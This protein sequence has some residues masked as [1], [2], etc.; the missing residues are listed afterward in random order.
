MDVSMPSDIALKHLYSVQ[1]V[2]PLITPHRLLFQAPECHGQVAVCAGLP[3]RRH[4]H[5][6]GAITGTL[7]QE[8]W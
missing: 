6:S 2:E 5:P 8:P 7:G 3:Q 4:R 1:P